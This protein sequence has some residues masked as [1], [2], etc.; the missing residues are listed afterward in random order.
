MGEPLP[1]RPH[2]LP[3]GAFPQS[4]NSSLERSTVKNKGQFG[5]LC[6]HSHLSQSES[7]GA[8]EEWLGPSADVTSTYAR[9]TI[10]Q[11]VPAQGV[12]YHR[13]AFEQAA[14]NGQSWFPSNGNEVLSS[15]PRSPNTR[16][17]FGPQPGLSRSQHQNKGHPAAIMKTSGTHHHQS[18]R[19]RNRT[20]S[21]TEARAKSSRTPTQR[22]RGLS[23]T[24][25]RPMRDKYDCSNREWFRHDVC[26]WLFTNVNIA[27]QFGWLHF[28]YAYLCIVAYHPSCR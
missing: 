1:N 9:S 8:E 13:S 15:S 2:T 26:F 3:S 18:F 5:R 22:K 11:G 12:V 14:G 20:S 4:N 10:L 7:S 6:R 17:Y 25:S 27:F 16:S 23:E 21:E 24:E 19:G 28:C